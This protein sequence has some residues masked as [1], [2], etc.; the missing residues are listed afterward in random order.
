MKRKTYRYVAGLYIIVFPDGSAYVGGSMHSLYRRVQDHLKTLWDG[1]HPNEKMQAVYTQCGGFGLE[2]TMQELDVR[3]AADLAAAE[4]E[5][6]LHQVELRGRDSV[7][8]G[9]LEALPGDYGSPVDFGSS[10]SLR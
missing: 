7:L 1:E 3:T 4:T 8:N 10:V 2:I 5:M 6:I 9:S